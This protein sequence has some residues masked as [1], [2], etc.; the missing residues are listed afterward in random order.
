MYIIRCIRTLSRPYTVHM[1]YRTNYMRGKSA[2][3]C[4]VE[5]IEP[6]RGPLHRF[7]AF[8]DRETWRHALP[9]SP[10]LPLA[11]VSRGAQSRAKC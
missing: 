6:V 9:P 1:P 7:N 5:S 3:R 11:H 2:E 8:T 4:V 10:L